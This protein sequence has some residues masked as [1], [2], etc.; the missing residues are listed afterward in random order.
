MNSSGA[1]QLK[2]RNRFFQ[3]NALLYYFIFSFQF[4]AGLNYYPCSI[5]RIFHRGKVIISATKYG[6]LTSKEKSKGIQ[7][8]QYNIIRN[9][10]LLCALPVLNYLKQQSRSCNVNTEHNCVLLF[11]ANYRTKLT[12]LKTINYVFGFL[13]TIYRVNKSQQGIVKGVVTLPC[14][15][16]SLP[17]MLCDSF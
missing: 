16:Y 12:Q 4:S 1:K 10:L 8:F 5:T 2:A 17:S 7:L 9:M 14:S 11:S 3:G 6:F 13:F 15:E